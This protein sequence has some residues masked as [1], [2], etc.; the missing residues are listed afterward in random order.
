MRSKDN[1]RKYEEYSG[2]GWE[3]MVLS[4]GR[5]TWK[6]VMVTWDSLPWIWCQAIDTH[7]DEFVQYHSMTIILVSEN[8]YKSV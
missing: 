4:G 6:T 8:L 5:G 7:I 2:A 1:M 3:G